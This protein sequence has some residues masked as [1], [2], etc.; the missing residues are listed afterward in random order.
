MSSLVSKGID[1]SR[2][3]AEGY[4]DQYPVGDN[5]T[6]EGRT[7]NRRIALRVTQK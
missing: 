4:G 3:E 1:P 6:E 7:K 2:L 5:S